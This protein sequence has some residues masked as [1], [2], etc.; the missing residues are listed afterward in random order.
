[1]KLNIS[2]PV[3]R[4]GTGA[5]SYFVHLA[6]GLEDRGHDV[7]LTFYP[8]AYEASAQLLGLRY[9]CPPGTHIVH[10]KAE[11]GFALRTRGAPLVMTLAHSVFDPLLDA[12]KSR[13]TK[14]YHELVKRRS[15]RRSLERAD[16]VVTVSEYSRQR[17]MLDFGCENVTTIHNG[18]DEKRFRI[19]DAHERAFRDRWAKGRFKLFYVGNVMKRKGSDLL[20]PIMRELGDDFVLYYTSGFRGGAHADVASNMHPV[21]RLSDEEIVAAYN[22]CDAL[23]FP[24]RMEGFGYPVAEAMAC[25]KPVVCTNSSSMPEL[26][27]HGPGGRLCPVDDVGAFVR[28]VRELAAMR[29]EERV[30][31]GAFNRQ[32]VLDAFTHDRCIA[33]YDA[34]YQGLVARV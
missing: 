22:E 10:T 30:A 6:R 5:D 28:A 13:T 24:S 34:L 21:G 19:L 16:A 14:A 3:I 18:V 32:R 17:I 26:I 25:G 33:R 11:H 27:E 20:T 1:M 29:E 23:L 2:M 4:N 15:I 31:M 7:S 8:R 9:R 12:H